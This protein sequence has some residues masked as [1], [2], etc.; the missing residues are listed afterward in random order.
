[1]PTHYK[2]SD[3]EIEALNTYIKFR[4]AAGEVEHILERELQQ[5]GLTES[6]FGVLEV[7]L[8]LG[9]MSQR[10]IS[11]KLFTS[12]ANITTILDNLEKRDLI[13][14]ERCPS[15]RRAFTIHLTAA[16]RDLIEHA[17]PPH[18]RRIAELFAVL[19]PE[20]QRELGR[21]CKVLGLQ[22]RDCGTSQDPCGL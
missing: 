6:Q 15:D 17:F 19:S 11:R 13:L 1:M 9:P 12:G 10:C 4:R 8:H 22:N 5:A 2:G 7:L 20:Q 21:L 16:G 3:V 14:R 18:A